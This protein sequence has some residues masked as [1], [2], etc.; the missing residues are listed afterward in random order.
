MAIPLSLHGVV[1]KKDGTTVE[2]NVGD[3][4][5]DPVFFISDLLV[6]LAGEQ[7]EKKA[8]K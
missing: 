5:D 6:H 3:N 8:A 2:I 4:E 1:V 7:M